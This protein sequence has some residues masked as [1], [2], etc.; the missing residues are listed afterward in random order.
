MPM[1]QDFS[2]HVLEALFE[3]GYK[4][5]DAPVRGQSVSYLVEHM[6]SK[7]WRIR[8]AWGEFEDLLR[9]NG[10]SVSEGKNNRNQRCRVAY[11]QDK[12]ED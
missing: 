8:T 6:R 2:S 3:G 9:E 4:V 5:K 11:L 7:G 10:F 12:K 1:N